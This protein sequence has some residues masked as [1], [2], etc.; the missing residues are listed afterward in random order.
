MALFFPET[1]DK[2][3]PTTTEEA[4]YI[5]T[6]KSSIKRKAKPIIE[7]DEDVL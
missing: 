6:H 2:V 4:D 1:T 3:L 7:T 5:G